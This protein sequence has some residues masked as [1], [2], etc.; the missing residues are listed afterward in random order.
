MQE[1]LSTYIESSNIEHIPVDSTKR[2]KF[3]RIFIDAETIGTCSEMGPSV[4]FCPALMDNI[5]YSPF[6]FYHPIEGYRMFD[7]TGCI[8][9]RVVTLIGLFF[10]LVKYFL[11][12]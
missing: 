2:T 3:K 5:P 4:V 8:G 6:P 11:F 9:A 10:I 7:A 1:I 12:F